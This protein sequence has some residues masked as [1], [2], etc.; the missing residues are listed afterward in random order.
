MLKHGDILGRRRKKRRK[1]TKR[2]VRIPT[3][4]ECPRC[5]A[6]TLSITMRKIGENR[7]SAIISCGN[8]GLLDDE[9]FTDIP[10]I[11]QTLDVYSKFID[12]YL[13]GRARI[14]ST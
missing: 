14:K 7:S 1:I 12:L 8:C 10:S 6:K 3:V 11:Y 9:D 13:E 2:E 5:A 4:F